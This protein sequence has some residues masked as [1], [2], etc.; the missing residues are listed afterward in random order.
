MSPVL[1]PDTQNSCLNMNLP[2]RRMLRK[3]TNIPVSH[4]SVVCVS[5]VTLKSAQACTLDT[6]YFD[7]HLMSLVVL[8]SYT[9]PVFES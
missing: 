2:Q 1:L 6:L 7:F 4:V 3:T 8:C 5:Y 9:Y